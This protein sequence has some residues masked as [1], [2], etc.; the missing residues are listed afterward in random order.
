MKK[1]KQRILSGEFKSGQKLPS[2]RTLGNAYGVST[3]VLRNVVAQLKNE[4]LL[5]SS[6]R[7]G[8]FIPEN[9]KQHE[10]C[11]VINSIKIGTMENYF[12]ALLQCASGHNCVP[13]I[14]LP[15]WTSIESMLEK[16]HAGYLSAHQQNSFPMKNCS[17]YLP[18]KISFSVINMSGWRANRNRQFWLIGI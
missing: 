15:S 17:G 1:L 6:N 13:M 14:A 11:G 9:L 4:G 10:L 2:M 8:L 5:E 18:K 3:M 7:S 12:E 16:K